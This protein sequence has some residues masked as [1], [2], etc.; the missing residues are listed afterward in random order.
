MSNGV[1][2]IMV[3]PR[4]V[5]KLAEAIFTLIKDEKLRRQMGDP[6]S[7]GRSNDWSVLARQRLNVYQNTLDGVNHS[8]PSRSEGTAPSER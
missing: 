2:G 1:E 3:P 4:N 8:G 6:A 5:E 7:P